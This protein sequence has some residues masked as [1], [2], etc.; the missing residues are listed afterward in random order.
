MALGLPP[1]PYPISLQGTMSGEDILSQQERLAQ[2]YQQMLMQN[3]QAAAGQA[4]QAQQQYQQ[5]AAQPAPQLNPADVFVPTLL[6]NIASVISRDPG[7]R[8]RAQQ[9]MEQKQS[10]LLR[11]RQE[12]LL[13]LRDVYSQKADEARRA[14]DLEGQE[15]FRLK[16][17]K[18]NQQAE[19]ISARHQNALE[20]EK[21]RHRNRLIEIASRG[22]ADIGAD[23]LDDIV[24]S[25]SSGQT[26]IENFPIRVRSQIVSRLKQTGQTITPPK[27]RETVSA[28]GAARGVLDEIERL[29]G[30]VNTA[31]GPGRFAQGL[32]KTAGAVSQT[33]LDAT[34]LN[35]ARQG[36]LASIARAAGEKGV[37]TEQD[38][39]RARNLLPN[40]FDSGPAAQ[41]KLAQ[42]RS[43]LDSVELKATKAYTEPKA[44]MSA[45]DT[46]KTSGAT[47]TTEEEFDFDFV[48]GRGL[49]P[50]R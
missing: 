9:G 20:L 49:V 31:K 33:D 45:A 24:E 40:V 22:Q 12:N 42:L 48:P 2:E 23:D 46:T 16:L 44:G 47:A 14:N 25:I 15:R 29:S 13:A 7:F 32:K 35:T 19:N 28:L 38:V 10:D 27:V 18:L 37:L 4:Q 5:A 50:V 43:F 8:Q 34:M 41:R 39:T 11:A 21:E 1:V 36:F 6:S 17:D 26:K 3:A 30:A